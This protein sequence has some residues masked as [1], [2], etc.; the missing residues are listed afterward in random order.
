MKQ[1]N[2]PEKEISYPGEKT[3][4]KV[5]KSETGL[6]YIDMKEGTGEMPKKGQTIIVHYSG[7]LLDGKK[8]DSSVDRNEPFQ[9][10]I[11][12]GQVIK[13]WDEGMMS[14]KVGGNRKLIIPYNLAYGERGIP[15]TIPAKATLVFDVELLSIK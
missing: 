4:N 3:E 9:T 11:G 15:G 2:K 8:F 6:E 13:G 7:F 14:M 1:E 12:V 5:V 10:T